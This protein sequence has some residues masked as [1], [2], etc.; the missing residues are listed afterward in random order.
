MTEST[1]ATFKA[2]QG[3][4]FPNII[5]LLIMII[6]SNNLLWTCSVYIYFGDDWLDK[7]LGVFLKC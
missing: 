2:N 3:R 6:F 1:D 4:G 5:I 7:V